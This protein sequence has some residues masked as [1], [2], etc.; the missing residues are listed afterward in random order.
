MLARSAALRSLV[1]LCATIVHPISAATHAQASKPQK[2]VVVTGASSGIGRKITERLA[3]KGFFV[4]AG[5]RSQRDLDELS[6][7]KNVQ[8]VRLDVTV[9]GDIAAAVA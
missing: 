7:I 1:I 5:A 4:Y 8:G 6:A 2:A 3:S 9:P